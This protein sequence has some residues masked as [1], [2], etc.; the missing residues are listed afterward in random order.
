MVIYRGFSHE[1]WWFSIAMLNYQR[2]TTFENKPENKGGRWWWFDLAVAAISKLEPKST[3][4]SRMGWSLFRALQYIDHWKSR[5]FRVKKGFSK[6][7][8][9]L[10][11]CFLRLWWGFYYVSMRFQCG[12]QSCFHEVSS[13]FNVVSMWF[14]CGFHWVS[15]G[16]PCDFHQVPMGNP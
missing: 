2:V 13:G 9:L 12:V 6:S 10:L 1:K 3:T 11:Y 4:S 14:P 5:K 16:F 8:S 7:C 15:M